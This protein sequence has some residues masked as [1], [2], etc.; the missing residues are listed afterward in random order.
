MSDVV[1]V[2]GS[3]LEKHR[4]FR[5]LYDGKVSTFSENT[6]FFLLRRQYS[7]TFLLPETNKI[8]ATNGPYADKMKNRTSGEPAEAAGEITPRHTLRDLA[9]RDPLRDG[10]LRDPAAVRQPRYFSGST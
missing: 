2:L 10:L 3:G 6:K 8:R 1:T 4:R 9:Q 5:R 7:G